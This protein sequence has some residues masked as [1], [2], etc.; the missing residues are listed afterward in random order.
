MTGSKTAPSVV[1]AVTT[2]C[3]I[4]AASIQSESA[5]R[6]MK[7]DVHQ[8]VV[9]AKTQT[10][11]WPWQPAIPEVARVARHGKKVAPL[12]I[13][14]LDDDPDP[15]REGFIDER[16][17]QQAALALC[18]IYGVIEQCGRVWCNRALPE[19][20]RAVKQFW[21]SQTFRVTAVVLIAVRLSEAATVLA[22]E[23]HQVLTI[24]GSRDRLKGSARTTPEL[25]IFY[26]LSRRL[27]EKD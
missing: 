11:L 13:E 17:Q 1:L 24:I 9:R 16:V 19:E 10:R 22:L 5:T 12:L 21:A 23:R 4:A 26:P 18:K 27:Y 7:A 6:Q 2:L 15:V 25:L 3:S 20:N 8:L 14:L